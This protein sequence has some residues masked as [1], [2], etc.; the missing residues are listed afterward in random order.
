V[1]VRRGTLGQAIAPKSGAR[2]RLPVAAKGRGN[3]VVAQQRS[4]STSAGARHRPA[5]TKPVGDWFIGLGCLVAIVLAVV[6][7]NAATIAVG[8]NPLEPDRML[9]HAAGAPSKADDYVEGLAK[10]G[11]ARLPC[12]PAAPTTRSQTCFRYAR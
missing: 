4:T 6:V 7:G 3:P 8:K 10:L 5:D 1:L 12:S 2:T 9:T 11:I